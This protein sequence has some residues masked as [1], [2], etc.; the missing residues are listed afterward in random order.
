DQLLDLNSRYGGPLSGPGEARQLQ[1]LIGG[2]PFLTRRALDVL[3]RGSMDFATLLSFGDR[4]DGPFGDHLKRVLISVTE[5]HAVQQVL[6]SALADGALAAQ[7][8]GYQRL[9]A[10]GV[11]RQSPDN[12]AAFSCELYRRYLSRHL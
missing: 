5:L 7:D 11:L 10:A 9:L 12:R 3:A 8:E 4:D 2:Q 6:K 1:E